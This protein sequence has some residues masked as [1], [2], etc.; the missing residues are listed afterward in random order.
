MT[1]KLTIP[2]EELLVCD[3]ML[4]ALFLMKNEKG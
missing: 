1:N 4:R 3:I 2:F